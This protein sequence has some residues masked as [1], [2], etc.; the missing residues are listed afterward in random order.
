MPHRL[1]PVASVYGYWSEGLASDTI[2]STGH[3]PEPM[4]LGLHVPCATAGAGALLGL[5]EKKLACQYRN[6]S[7]CVTPPVKGDIAVGR[8]VRYALF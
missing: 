3:R 5:I 8:Q 6:L 1:K 7:T 2:D 4:I